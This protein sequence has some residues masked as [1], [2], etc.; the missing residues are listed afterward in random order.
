M[1]KQ[2]MFYVT[3]EDMNELICIVQENGGIFIHESGIELDQNDLLHYTDYSY[4]YK[5]YYYVNCYIKT[6]NSKIQ[7]KYAEKINRIY[8]DNDNSELIDIIMPHESIKIE[9]GM[10]W[11][12]FWHDPKNKEL[13]MIFDCVKKYIRKYYHLS[14]DK[15]YYLGPNFYDLYIRGKCVP[16]SFNEIPIVVD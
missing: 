6:K 7:Y 4:L 13:D 12:R 10:V 9:N 14:K 2:I 5:K 15:S 16:V 1:G 11:S 8:I 3:Q